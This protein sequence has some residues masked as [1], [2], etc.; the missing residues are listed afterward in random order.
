MIR[1]VA[2]ASRSQSSVR[3]PDYLCAENPKSAIDIPLGKQS[4][5]LRQHPQ[6]LLPNPGISVGSDVNIATRSH[7]T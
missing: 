4:R 2:A 6:S 3:R 7:Y 1:L 5:W